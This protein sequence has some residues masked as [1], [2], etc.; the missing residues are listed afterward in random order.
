MPAD[1][2]ALESTL[3]STVLTAFQNIRLAY[4]ASVV[5]AVLDRAV[6]RVGEYD[7]TADR[8]DRITLARSDAAGFANGQTIAA[9]PASYTVGDLAAMPKSSWK[10]DRIASDDGYQVVWWLK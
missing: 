10:L 2:A 6:D 9:D 7:L 5:G 4:G 1:F 3:S 8:R